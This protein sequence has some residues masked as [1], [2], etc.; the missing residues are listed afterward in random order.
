MYRKGGIV[1]YPNE[2][3]R[4]NTRGSY[5]NLHIFFIQKIHQIAAAIP[6]KFG[7]HVIQQQNR[8]VAPSF[9]Q[10][11]NLCHLERQYEA[12]LFSL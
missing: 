5:E 9:S 2:I 8:G 6:V 7:C 10:I 3:D 11:F 12:S 1:F 4:I